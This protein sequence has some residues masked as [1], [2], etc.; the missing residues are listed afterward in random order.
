MED[1][2]GLR[3]NASTLRQARTSSWRVGSA[4]TFAPRVI[5]GHATLPISTR[6]T[7]KWRCITASAWCPRGL[8]IKA[9]FQPAEVDSHFESRSGRVFHVSFFFAISCSPTRRPRRA[10]LPNLRKPC[11]YGFGRVFASPW[12]A[13]E[14]GARRIFMSAFFFCDFARGKAFWH[15]LSR[16]HNFVAGVAPTGSMLQP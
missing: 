12:R 9:R 8:T 7:K 10:G 6:P 3:G 14:T 4:R 11:S 13:P 5:S 15:V 2:L 1:N 16:S